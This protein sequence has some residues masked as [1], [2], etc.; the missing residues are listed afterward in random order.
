MVK[1]HRFTPLAE[2][3]AKYS[4]YSD[5]EKKIICEGTKSLLCVLSC[6]ARKRKEFREAEHHALA[7]ILHRE[8]NN[9]DTRNR[10]P[11]RESALTTNSVLEKYYS[12]ARLIVG[13]TS[14]DKER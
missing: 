9:K 14:W 13:N 4:H 2:I 5:E 1:K 8:P 10:H 7:R 3:E 11:N 6:P 12:Q